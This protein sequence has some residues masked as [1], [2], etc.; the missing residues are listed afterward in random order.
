MRISNNIL[1][2]IYIVNNVLIKPPLHNTY[3]NSCSYYNYSTK[4]HVSALFGHRQAYE[5]VVLV[6]VHSVA[7][8]NRIPWFTVVLS[9]FSG[10]QVLFKNNYHKIKSDI[11]MICLL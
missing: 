6:K 11:K 2:K 3:S 5:T 8:I 10:L 4:R 9:I 1:K 7:F